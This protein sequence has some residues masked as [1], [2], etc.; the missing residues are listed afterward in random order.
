METIDLLYQLAQIN[1]Q[2][3]AVLNGEMGAVQAQLSMV[4]WFMGINI[5]AWVGIIV[6]GLAKLIFKKS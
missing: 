1:A 2:H 6:A 5:V 4:V 3:I